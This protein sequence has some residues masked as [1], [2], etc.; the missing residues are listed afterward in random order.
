MN[1]V[2]IAIFFLQCCC[3]VLAALPA[4]VN[5]TVESVN[6][7]HSLRWDPGPGT[8]PGTT[9][10]VRYSRDS[11]QMQTLH[12][13]D[14]SAAVVKQTL[15]NC[16]QDV[17][18]LCTIEVRAVHRNRKSE[19]RKKEFTPF[20]DTLLGPPEV[21]VSVCGDCLNLTV[22]LPRGK[23]ELSISQIYH[24]F[25]YRIFWKHATE[26]KVWN[27]S[28]TKNSLV[29]QNLEPAAQYCVQVQLQVNTNKHTLPSGWVCAFTSSRSQI[30]VLIIL[31]CVS[32]LLIL[33]G[34]VLVGLIHTGVL[35]TLKTQ[36]PRVMYLA[37]AHS[38]YY[39]Y[40]EETTPDTVICDS[41]CR[42][43]GGGAVA[44][45]PRRCSNEEEEEDD[46]EEEDN[47][48]DSVYVNRMA[49][50]LEGTS[51][52]TA[53]HDTTGSFSTA[54]TALSTAESSG[55]SGVAGEEPEWAEPPGGDGILGLS[56][57][58]G[59]RQKNLG[60]TMDGDTDP[61]EDVNLLSVVLWAVDGQGVAEDQT[62][63]LWGWQPPL[64]STGSGDRPAMLGA[65]RRA[66][67]P[68]LIHAAPLLTLPDCEQTVT[69]SHYLQ[70]HANW[71]EEV[72]E[73]EEEEEE[74]ECSDY[75]RR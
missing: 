3:Q 64:L 2:L 50:H 45:E 17:L 1:Y 8:P 51:S 62:G 31:A 15:Q 55:N 75:M 7:E 70:T 72:E 4:P 20:T 63:G 25:T 12:V 32:G 48:G 61:G 41:G 67:S 24:V 46:E 30:P 56:E 29:L 22:T 34:L 11:K 58:G 33:G 9:Y 60:E 44:Q 47:A 10:R 18:E 53:S 65:D 52:G 26:N 73:E 14:S 16:T 71:K 69:H 23:A 27:T 36:L 49:G 6:F 42:K 39:F 21:T 13:P 38:Y 40:V 5:I 28:T 59:E 68:E 54:A 37:E 66:D 57:G 35:C 74:E 43:K 19:W